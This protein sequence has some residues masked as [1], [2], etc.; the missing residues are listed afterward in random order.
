MRGC[1]SNIDAAEVQGANDDER[2]EWARQELG[3]MIDAEV[4]RLEEVKAKLDPSLIEADRLEAADRC[5]FDL[6]PA[7]TLVRKY[8]AAT[9]RAMY[10]H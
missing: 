3:R 5:L 2:A 7:M 4:A 10:K 9:E 8:E 1:F 6:Q